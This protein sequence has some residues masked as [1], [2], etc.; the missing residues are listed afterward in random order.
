MVNALVKLDEETNKILNIVK[1]KN[2]LKD[3]G[4]AIDFI[5]K[6]Y[7]EEEIDII[8]DKGDKKEDFSRTYIH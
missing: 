2:S 4:Q 6:K 1:A 8:K 3:K 7:A 5:A